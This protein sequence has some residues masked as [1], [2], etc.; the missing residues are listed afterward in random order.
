M[1][2]APKYSI[3]ENFLLSL[4]QP[5]NDLGDILSTYVNIMSNIVLS[6]EVDMTNWRY[7]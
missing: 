5:P 4:H 1:S 3:F 7:D 2:N 6:T